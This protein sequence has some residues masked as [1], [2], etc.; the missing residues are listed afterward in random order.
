VLLTPFD[1]AEAPVVASWSEPGVAT[2][3]WCGVTAAPAGLIAGWG[4]DPDVLPFGLHDDAELV[5]YG[6]LWPDAEEG[7]I[8]LARIIVA[9]ARRGTGVGRRLTRLLAAEA[10]R[11]DTPA[12]ADV[13]LRVHPDN[14][15]ALRCYLGAGFAPVPADE[16][17]GWNAGQPVPYAWLR[18]TSVT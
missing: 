15:V 17:S 12:A 2:V 14:P 18:M 16:L 4:A 9:P 11:L 10:G 5:G 8:E 6:E 1:P 13:V 3:R 7:E